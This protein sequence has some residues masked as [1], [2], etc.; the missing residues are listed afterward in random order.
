MGVHAM[1]LYRRRASEQNP[2]GEQNNERNSSQ[3]FAGSA[4]LNNCRSLR[5]S[6]RSHRRNGARGVSG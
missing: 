4:D 3:P 2:Y 1:S 5:S 6:F